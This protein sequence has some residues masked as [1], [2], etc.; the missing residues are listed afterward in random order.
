MIILI[1]NDLNN[2]FVTLPGVFLLIMEIYVIEI[3]PIING[4]IIPKK[5]SLAYCIIPPAI[6][7]Q[8]PKQNTPMNI[9]N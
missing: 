6:K 1:A 9:E 7:P 5:I 2:T 4:A 8:V 3:T